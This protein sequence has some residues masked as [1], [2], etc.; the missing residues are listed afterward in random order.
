MLGLQNSNS[1]IC[2]L[3]V[4]RIYGGLE[5][6]TMVAHGRLVELSVWDALLL[7]TVWGMIWGAPYNKV[8]ESFNTQATHDVLVHQDQLNKVWM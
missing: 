7:V 6:I 2:H 1:T 4:I 5:F 3:N 8:E